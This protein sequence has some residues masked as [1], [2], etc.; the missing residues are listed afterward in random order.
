MAEPKQLTDS[1]ELV[2]KTIARVSGLG[3][4]DPDAI[5]FTDGSFVLLAT[6]YYGAE[7]VDLVIDSH[8]ASPRTLM[9]LGF[10]DM[11]ECRAR[12]RAE[13]EART[14]ISEANERAQFERLKAKFEPQPSE[15]K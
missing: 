5:T 4:N 15:A 8:A 6:E 3:E 11:N 9:S 7:E 10:I 14:A 12:E 13:I 1:A 2:G